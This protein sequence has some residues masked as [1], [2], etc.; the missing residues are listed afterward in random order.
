MSQELARHLPSSDVLGPELRIGDPDGHRS[1]LLY[2]EPGGTFSI[3]ALVWR[4]GQVTPIHDHV[5]WCVFGVVQ[6]EE[7]EE[8]ICSTRSEA[9]SSRRG[10]GR[11][12]RET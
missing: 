10:R 3:V 8:L 5:T 9:A 4:P 2:S 1:H 12:G 6:G 11:T 7:R